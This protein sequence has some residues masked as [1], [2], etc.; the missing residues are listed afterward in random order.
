MQKINVDSFGEKI[1]VDFGEDISTNTALSA[2]LRPQSGADAEKTPVLETADL[3]VEDKKLLANQFVSYTTQSGDFDDW[4]GTWQIKAV[5]T[6]PS[7]TIS[8]EY[9]KFVVGE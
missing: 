9:V 7:M 1:Y 6:L 3:W 2:T 4:V 8:T 5:A